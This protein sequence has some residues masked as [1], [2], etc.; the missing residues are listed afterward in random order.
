MKQQNQELLGKIRTIGFFMCVCELLACV[1]TTKTKK[2][3]KIENNDAM[4]G[5][6]QNEKY[7]LLRF[8]NKTKITHKMTKTHY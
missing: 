1:Q 3:T 2:K 7:A 8:Q 4:Q 5:T 6:L